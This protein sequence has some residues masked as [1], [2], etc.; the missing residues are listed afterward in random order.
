MTTLLV[1]MAA[2]LIGMCVGIHLEYRNGYLDRHLRK[3]WPTPPAAAL[4]EDFIDDC[5]QFNR[6]MIERRSISACLKCR[7]RFSESAV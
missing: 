2:F 6:A 1:G 3:P 4:H 5:E 7:R